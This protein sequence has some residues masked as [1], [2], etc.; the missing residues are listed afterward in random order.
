[1]NFSPKPIQTLYIWRLLVSQ[2]EAWLSDIKPQLKPPLRRELKEAGFIT[3]EK[4]STPKGSKG[5]YVQLT[6]QGWAWATD[7]L[8]APLPSRSTAA[9]PVLHALLTKLKPVLKKHNIPLIEILA[10][11]EPIKPVG[12]G[13]ELESRVHEAYFRLSGGK[14]NVRVR[15]AQLRQALPD[16]ARDTLDRLLLKLQR[17]EK[18]VLYP[19]DDPQEISPEDIEAAITLT[20]FSNHIIYMR[21]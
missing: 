20:G 2:G 14:A 4:R 8:E 11:A 1:M 5:L 13:E 17:A 18:L 21:K 7:N 9:V 19:L 6:D 3:E 16:V 10:P 12:D 15:L